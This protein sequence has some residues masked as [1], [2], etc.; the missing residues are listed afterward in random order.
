MMAALSGVP[1]AEHR[2]PDAA[3]PCER[4]RYYTSN[5]QHVSINPRLTSL[6][7]GAGQRGMQGGR[8]PSIK[9]HV[10]HVATGVDVPPPPRGAKVKCLARRLAPR[11]EGEGV[12]NAHL[13]DVGEKQA[14]SS[15]CRPTRRVGGLELARLGVAQAHHGLAAAAPRHAEP[16]RRAVVDKAP[17]SAT[18]CSASRPPPTGGKRQGGNQVAFFVFRH[19]TGNHASGPARGPACRCAWRGAG[20]AGSAMHIAKRTNATRT[21]LLNACGGDAGSRQAGARCVAGDF[22]FPPSSP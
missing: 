21:G 6:P 17:R 13:H 12:N 7:A 1:A 20:N 18:Q 9:T 4:S 5:L 15:L 3:R 16:R 2:H 14:G 10:C 11:R 8:T 22:P 19:H